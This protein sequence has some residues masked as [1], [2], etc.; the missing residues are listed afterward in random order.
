V[1]QQHVSCPGSTKGSNRVQ[2]AAGVYVVPLSLEFRSAV[3]MNLYSTSAIGFSSYTLAMP[4]A[5][6]LLK[7]GALV[8]LE[9]CDRSGKSTQCRMLKDTLTKQ[10]VNVELF[11]FPG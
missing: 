4:A 8:V 5:S 7:R 1:V 11:R 10:G 2:H 3:H 9:G 6:D